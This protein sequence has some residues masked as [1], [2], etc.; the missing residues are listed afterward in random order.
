MENHAP[1]LIR[2][3]TV[4]QIANDPDFNK[5]ARLYAEECRP[6]GMPEMKLD[7]DTY[8]RLEDVGML[9]VYGA[10]LA[11]RK[12]LVGFVVVLTPPSLH[13]STRIATVDSI[14]VLPE[15][16]KFGTGQR[17]LGIAETAAMLTGCTGIF[18]NAPTGGRLSRAMAAVGYKQAYSLFFRGFKN[19]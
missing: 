19:G 1:V 14:Y 11:F 9:R 12:K 4:A 18:V 15:H 3:V 13:Y 6:D 17:L 8:Q 2:K 10:C 16:R 7:F 5:L